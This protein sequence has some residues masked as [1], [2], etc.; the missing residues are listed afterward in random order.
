M[1]VIK[2][3]Q[4]N[5]SSLQHS[6]V[7]NGFILCTLGLSPN[8]EVAIF[9]SYVAVHLSFLLIMISW[10]LLFLLYLMHL[11]FMLFNKWSHCF[12]LEQELIIPLYWSVATDHYHFAQVMP[13]GSQSQPAHYTII[14][15]CTQL[16]LMI[17]Y[18][19]HH[20]CAWSSGS[21]IYRVSVCIYNLMD[22]V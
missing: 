4:G 13:R 19:D 15:N 21:V 11:T 5:R 18:M 17:S 6:E 10:A 9:C 14:L 8:V 22:D 7:S 2:D 3:A 20:M 12:T 1:N 16:I